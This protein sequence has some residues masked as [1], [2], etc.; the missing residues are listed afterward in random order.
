MSMVISNVEINRLRDFGPGEGVTDY[1]EA[2]I[3]LHGRFD[4]YNDA[5]NTVSAIVNHLTG[6]LPEGM[7]TADARG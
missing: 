1:Y 6:G 4:N 5:H 3:T 2:E 7:D